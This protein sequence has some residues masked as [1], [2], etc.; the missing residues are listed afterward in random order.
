M[1]FSLPNFLRRT[2]PTALENYFTA[3]E[4][5]PVSGINWESKPQLLLERLLEA[6]NSLPNQTA[7]TCS[8]ISSAPLSYAMKL[9]NVLFSRC[10][11]TTCWKRFESATA[12]KHA[13][14]SF[15]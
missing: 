10:S 2:P 15:S 6:I 9:V 8:T 1:G 13:L 5:S 14:C 7:N 4:F 3:C 12:M 11:L